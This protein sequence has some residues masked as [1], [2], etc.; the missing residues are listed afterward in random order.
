MLC[1]L[2]CDKYFC[3]LTPSASALLYWWMPA[4]VKVRHWFWHLPMGADDSILQ[5]LVNLLDFRA[6]NGGGGCASASQRT[7]RWLARTESIKHSFHHH[8]PIRDSA[9]RI[10]RSSHGSGWHK[11]FPLVYSS[12]RNGEIVLTVSFSRDPTV[13]LNRI[14]KLFRTQT[15]GL[16]LCETKVTFQRSCRFECSLV[17][18]IHFSIEKLLYSGNRKQWMHWD[19]LLS[20]PTHN[21]FDDSTLL[22]MTE[23]ST[24][25]ITS[26]LHQ[27]ICETMQ[28][29][30]YKETRFQV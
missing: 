8:V 29:S 4:L 23:W 19:S 5:L 25:S 26:R 2:P 27:R 11:F 10:I 28:D 18:L 6:E 7:E 30:I 22:Y 1:T 17:E 21:S 13:I 14:A 15:V 16:W 20:V 12:R 3:Y 9:T 24:N